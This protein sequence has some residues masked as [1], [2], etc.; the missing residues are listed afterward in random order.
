MKRAVVVIMMLVICGFTF[1]ACGNYF[2]LDL[3]DD[4]LEEPNVFFSF[5]NMEADRALAVNIDAVQ[6]AALMPQVLK[7]HPMHT[8][9]NFPV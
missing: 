1:I 3:D 2:K 8:V 4:K 6:N 5:W 9:M 7:S